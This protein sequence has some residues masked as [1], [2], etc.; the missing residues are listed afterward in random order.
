MTKIFITGESGTIPMTLQCL[1]KN[2]DCIVVN[3]Q[4]EQET[5]YNHF[6][7]H[8]SFKVRKPEIDF[9]DYE[10]L[11][12]IFKLAKG[13]AN[14]PDIIVHSGAFV[15]TDFC[16]SNEALAIKTNVEGTLNIVK[17]CN[18]FNIP[19]VYFSTTAIMDPDDYSKEKPISKNTKINPQTL[20]G[21]TKYAGELIVQNMCNTSKA[22]VRPVFGFGDYPD[23]LHSALTKLIYVMHRNLTEETPLTILLDPLIKKSY[24]RVENIARC[25]LDIAKDVLKQNYI[26]DNP[27]YKNPINIGIDHVNALNWYDIKEIICKIFVDKK[28][29]TK[30]LFDYIYK[31]KIFFKSDDD[32]LHYH[33]IKIDQLKERMLEFEKQDFFIDIK[34][35]IESTVDSV[36][37]NS[38]IKP[39]WL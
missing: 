28:L 20:Y 26:Y 3:E 2:N 1:A 10:K 15:G 33:N 29:C 39:Y 25:V 18:E 9:L 38:H 16:S 11:S 7:T 14:E 30:E 6:K 19:L 24:T 8:Q 17:I 36:V 35:G 5:F 27:I 37:K 22:I 31:I 13:T 34:Q 21:I 32:Y 4:I 23:D 12:A